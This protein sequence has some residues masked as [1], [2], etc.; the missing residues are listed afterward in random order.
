[1][2]LVNFALVSGATSYVISAFN[3]LFGGDNFGT[4]IKANN[5]YNMTLSIQFVRHVLLF[6]TIQCQLI[7]L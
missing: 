6:Y 3:K 1:M 5:V 4:F 2:H 7:L